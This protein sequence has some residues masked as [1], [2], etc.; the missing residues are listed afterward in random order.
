[1]KYLICFLPLLAFLVLPSPLALAHTPACTAQNSLSRDSFL[2]A[3]EGVL[4]CLE[5]K[6]VCRFADNKLSVGGLDEGVGALGFVFKNAGDSVKT[7][8]GFGN[9]DVSGSEPGVVLRV[10]N[11]PRGTRMEAAL[12]YFYNLP[13]AAS[14]PCTWTS[15]EEPLGQFRTGL[16]R[17]ASCDALGN[18]LVRLVNDQDENLTVVAG[19]DTDFAARYLHSESLDWLRGAKVRINQVALSVIRDKKVLASLNSFAGEAYQ[20]KSTIAFSILP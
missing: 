12:R 15:E 6:T 18:C 10:K 13:G 11:L 8:V 5:G 20:L 16:V 17:D 2:V 19:A 3:S 1:M 9:P 7:L 4:D 14:L